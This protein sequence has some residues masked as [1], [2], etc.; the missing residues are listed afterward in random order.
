[1]I[2]FA[3]IQ[4]RLTKEPELKYTSSGTAIMN[5]SIASDRY[6]GKDKPKETSFFDAVFFGKMAEAKHHHLFKGQMIAIVGELKQDR[7]E[8]DGK[9]N[10]KI[11]I[12]GNTLE[13]LQWRDSGAKPETSPAGDDDEFHDGVPF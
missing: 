8:K 13:I 10:S 7:W 2:N 11:Q 6:A 4:G 9:A 12:I 1:M 5:L 3:A